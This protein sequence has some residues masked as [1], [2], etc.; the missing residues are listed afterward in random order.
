MPPVVV[1][2]MATGVVIC[3]TSKLRIELACWEPEMPLME[4]ETLPDA[5]L[6]VADKVKV[7]VSPADTARLVGETV[8]PEGS[9]FAVIITVPEKPFFGRVWI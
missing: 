8:T 7:P 4:T 2:G 3:K 9:P 5:A 6:D 1:N